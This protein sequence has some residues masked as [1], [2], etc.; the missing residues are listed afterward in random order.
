MT[1]PRCRTL[2]LLAAAAPL[3][4]QAMGARTHPT[5][6]H[7]YLLLQPLLLARLEKVR[8]SPDPAVVP[9][10]GLPLP[11]ALP[12]GS[13]RSSTSL[14]QTTK[15]MSSPRP[16]GKT[17]TDPVPAFLPTMDKS[18]APHAEEDL[19]LRQHAQGHIWTLLSCVSMTAEST[20]AISHDAWKATAVESARSIR[21]VATDECTLEDRGEMRRMYTLV[22]L[23]RGNGCFYSE[24]SEILIFTLQ[25]V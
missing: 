24:R 23:V 4:L 10:A 25:G 16:R 12:S 21:S 6:T 9:L 3:P 19:N 7:F 20:R 13:T 8:R 5:A 1:S 11:E 18:D 14:F 2:V 22:S 15:T 17:S